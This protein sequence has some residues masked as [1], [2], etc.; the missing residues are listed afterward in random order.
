MSRIK[1]FIPIVLVFALIS[2]LLGSCGKEEFKI[3]ATMFKKDGLWG[4][5]DKEGNVVI[6]PRYN[7]AYDFYKEGIALVADSEGWKYIDIHGIEIITPFMDGADPDAFRDG[8]SRFMEKK[9]IGFFDKRGK[10]AIP[11]QFDKV[12]PFSEGLA[13]FCANNSKKVPGI[14]NVSVPES[15]GFI[16]KLGLEAI[17]P[18]YEA[19]ESFK[20]G[21]ARVMLKGDWHYIDKNG[22]LLE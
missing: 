11:P 9:K 16:D 22:R 6:K 2:I 18:V 14:D 20:N 8:L 4:Y 5:K 10:I 12:L 13:G 7:V 21:R 19:V 3:P 17:P 15:W 1:K